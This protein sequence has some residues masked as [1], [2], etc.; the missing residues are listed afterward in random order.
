MRF[1]AVLSA[2]AALGVAASP[3][4]AAGPAEQPVKADLSERLEVRL[5]TID[6]VALDK[7]ERT[8]PGLGKDAF[9]LF[10]DGKEEPIDTLDVFCGE[11]PEPDPQST[12][13]GKWATPGDLATGTRRVVLA[14]DYLHL[15]TVPCPDLD[16]PCMMHTKALEAYRAL[17]TDK[18]EIH[19]EEIMVVALTGG[20]RVEQPFT[21]D[22]D[23]VI[24]TLRRMEYDVT[25]WNG[26]FEHMTEM[27]FFRSLE[28][29]MTLLYPTPGPKS[30][31]LISAGNG[32]SDV[33][34]SD[35][36]HLATAA[37][38]VQARIYPVDCRGLYARPTAFT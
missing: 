2:L 10:V 17:L 19:D 8:V 36:T 13:M 28:A 16:G 22:R 35:F 6:V 23:A 33:Y 18:P 3:S 29:L 4:P 15:P 12:R 31:V 1:L 9:R 20:L 30:V 38:D 21:R 14:F 26:R 37:S 11:T 5:V 24:E 32:P 7:D 25:L 27:G 34:E